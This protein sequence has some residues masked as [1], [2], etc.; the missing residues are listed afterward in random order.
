MR[1]TFLWVA[2][3]A[4]SA[5]CR[6]HGTV[7]TKL[8]SYQYAVRIRCN[9]LAGHSIDRLGCRMLDLPGGNRPHETFQELPGLQSIPSTDFHKPRYWKFSRGHLP[10]ILRGQNRT[11][12]GG[13]ANSPGQLGSLLNGS[14]HNAF[15]I[16][17]PIDG[18]PSEHHLE[19]AMQPWEFVVDMLAGR[20][21]NCTVPREARYMST[22]AG[23]KRIRE[24]LSSISPAV[25]QHRFESHHVWLQHFFGGFPHIQEGLEA[26]TP[27]QILLAGCIGRGME[28]HS[29]ETPTA[30]W[31]IQLAGSK[32]W[33]VC[34]PIPLGQFEWH[35]VRG[36]T[37]DVFAWRHATTRAAMQEVGCSFGIAHTGDAI[38][39]PPN[40]LH[41]TL[42]VSPWSVGLSQHQLSVPEVPALAQYL[43]HKINIFNAEGGDASTTDVEFL[44]LTGTARAALPLLSDWWSTALAGGYTGSSLESETC[45]KSEADQT[46]K[47]VQSLVAKHE[48]L[49]LSELQ[50]L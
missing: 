6:N 28:I 22:S 15:S 50:L 20:S 19:H 5:E 4:F 42:N 39:Y 41:A 47:R 16:L 18:I 46:H 23:V 8:K 33:V 43:E 7:Q 9:F 24:L 13:S 26:G 1:T 29:D 31:Q 25:H 40:W 2:L 11:L 49:D 30:A 38:Y 12:R 44:P 32:A 3:F 45:D 27:W 48:S 37:D 17:D 10:Y 35:D 34:P 21:R 14:F 36:T